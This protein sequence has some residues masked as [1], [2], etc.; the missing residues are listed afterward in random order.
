MKAGPFIGTIAALFIASSATA[1]ELPR[2]MRLEVKGDATCLDADRLR[3]AMAVALGAD[4]IDEEA[5]AHLVVTVLAGE[6]LGRARWRVEDA[7][8]RVLRERT[9]TVT[10][11]CGALV[12]ETALSIAVAYETGAA[13]AA[14]CDTA[15]RAKIRE[16]VRAELI[17]ELRMDGIVPVL[18]A[19]GMLSAGF[20]ADPGWGAFL[21]G[22]VR[23]GEVFS[24]ALEARILFPSRVVD[25]TSQVFGL[26]AITFALVPCGRWKVLMGCGFADLGMLVGGGGVSAPGG[27]P[28]IATF[29]FGP[30]LAAHI[31]IGDRFGVR[32]WADLRIAPVPSE[33]TFYGGGRWASNP[34]SGL[35]GIGA[36]FQ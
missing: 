18:M 34:V 2:T 32:A 20:T 28:V 31:P 36:T 7:A 11:G 1:V 6:Q 8:G 23:F 12:R 5:A 33:V 27:L 16:E 35:F 13:P 10:G 21:G 25:D 29:G 30:R 26:T 19:G 15:C 14:P 22:E 17:K 3:E 24:T 9:I 4:P